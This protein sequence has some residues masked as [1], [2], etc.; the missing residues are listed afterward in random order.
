[1]IVVVVVAVGWSSRVGKVL[2]AV[3]WSEPV[4]A[5]ESL[6]ELS[7]EE[8][9]QELS[10]ALAK[11][12]PMFG[13]ESWQ[14]YRPSTFSITRPELTRGETQAKTCTM[15]IVLSKNGL[16]LEQRWL[17]SSQRNRTH[18]DFRVRRHG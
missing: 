18:L 5:L 14:L 6:E 4:R 2:L 16:A 8:C 9:R 15:G 1:M 3:R 11:E 7:F 12:R 13:L 17:C 10:F